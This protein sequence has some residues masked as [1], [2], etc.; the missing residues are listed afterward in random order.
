M[1]KIVGIYA[2]FLLAQRIYNR[3][4]GMMMDR[5]LSRMQ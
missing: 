5:Q 1:Q 4:Q 2:V 3:Q